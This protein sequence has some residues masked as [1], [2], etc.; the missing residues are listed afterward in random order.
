[1]IL[2]VDDDLDTCDSIAEVLVEHGYQVACAHD[3]RDA[4]QRLKNGPRPAA[5]ILDLM[6]PGINGWQLRDEMLKDDELADIPVIV[7]TAAAH[8]WGAPDKTQG[9][10]QKPFNVKELV[11]YV[12]QATT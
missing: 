10:L 3:G 12:Q 8:Y 4:L 7:V 6:M 1:M 11:E 5:I 9:R 2:V